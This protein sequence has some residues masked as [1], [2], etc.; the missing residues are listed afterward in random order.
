MIGPGLEPR[1]LVAAFD[2]DPVSLLLDTTSVRGQSACVHLSAGP[3]SR[4]V[5]RNF[6]CDLARQPCLPDHDRKQRAVDALEVAD[7]IRLDPVPD[8]AH[9]APV[10]QCFGRNAQNGLEKV[11]GRVAP[12]R[13]I[14]PF[15]ES[16]SRRRRVT[17]GRRYE[18]AASE[19]EEGSVA[20]PVASRPIEDVDRIAR[21]YPRSQDL[22][23]LVPVDQEDHGRADRFEKNIPAVAAA[24]RVAAGDQIKH[25]LV[26]EALRALAIKSAPLNG[27][28]PKQAGE[29]LRARQMNVRVGDR[30]RILLNRD[31]DHMGVGL[32][33][34]VLNDQS[35]ARP[36]CGR[37]QARMIEFQLAGR[38]EPAH[39][40]LDRG[41]VL[42]QQAVDMRTGHHL[43]GVSRGQTIQSFVHVHHQPMHAVTIGEACQ[44]GD[45]SGLGAARRFGRIGCFEGGQPLIEDITL[46]CVA[47]FDSLHHDAD[48]VPNCR[49]QIAQPG[50]RDPFVSQPGRAIDERFHGDEIEAS[51][52][53]LV[54]QVEMHWGGI[55]R[56]SCRRLQDA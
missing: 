9:R 43:L 53:A 35:F 33:D 7:E 14:Q 3:L 2:R 51:R 27:K 42:G 1:N 11:D 39:E 12:E 19:L 26:A 38:F 34:I 4:H 29:E 25:S 52:A 44:P 20:E 10:Q 50:R 40:R 41:A 22:A 30:H 48:I 23:S 13:A 8:E 21:G 6:A 46:R 16:D 47:G 45:F 32:T 5:A 56:V 55:A 31:H 49:S 36:A 17:N 15:A 24:G 18:F 28:I 54:P 37:R